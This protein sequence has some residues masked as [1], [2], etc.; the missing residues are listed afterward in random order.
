ML[1]QKMLNQKLTL[2]RSE[3]E[4]FIQENDVEKFEQELLVKREELEKSM[5]EIS[6]DEE[7]DFLERELEEHE[8]KEKEL[9]IKK[10]LF[11][12]QKKKLEEEIEAI[13]KQLN[14]IQDP[15]EEDERKVKISEEFRGGKNMKF[16]R[17]LQNNE[18]NTL[19]QQDDSKAFLSEL[20][21][22]VREK[23]AIT[24]GDLAIPTDFLGV[25]RA[26]LET[27]SKTLKHV[28]VKKL[29]GD[30][31]VLVAGNTPEAVWTEACAKIN[32]LTLGFSMVQLGAHK[33]AGY[34]PL[35][36]SLLALADIDLADEVMHAIA[37]S[38]GLALDK[39]VL[40][41]TG[42][43]MPVGIFTRLKAST[44][45]SWYGNKEEEFVNLVP[46]HFGEVGSSL[47][48]DKF[49]EALVLGLSKAVAYGQNKKVW[50]MNSQTKAFLVSKTVKTNSL[51]AFV[52]VDA[53]MPVVG[54]EIVELDFVPNGL[55]IGGY[56]ESYVLGERSG[57]KLTASEHAHFIE[58]NTIFKG[59]ALY[60]GRPA[61]AKSFVVVAL[62]EIASEEDLTI[63]FAGQ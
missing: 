13:E 29:N 62:S 43:N 4:A 41:G 8:E 48:G 53:Q 60:D 22:V 24:G 33:V 21:S 14:S 44:K 6:T 42:V 46:T 39:A 47:T 32:E 34:I 61:L 1:R 19:I 28:T 30:G 50:F 20:R 3:L 37:Q 7:Y 15:V 38:I 23:R 12:N 52:G 27:Y 11:E 36:N 56:G 45:P 35:C 40:F 51:G 25:L 49:V 58:D 10:E 16:F 17:N 2:K 5:D 55:I 9:V 18:L 63:T 31:K 57:A 59:V 54:G 26:N